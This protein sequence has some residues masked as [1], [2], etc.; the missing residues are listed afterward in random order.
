MYIHQDFVLCIFLWESVALGVLVH[1]FFCRHQ[2][3]YT[4]PVTFQAFS[5]EERGGGGGRE[6]RGGGGGR[7]GGWRGGGWEF[8]VCGL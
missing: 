7:E 5:G 8:S 4:T 3:P 2:L 1:I 6:G